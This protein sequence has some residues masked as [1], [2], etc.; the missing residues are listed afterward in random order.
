MSAAQWAVERVGED[1]VIT[2]ADD[3]DAFVYTMSLGMAA[4]IAVM[5]YDAIVSEKESDSGQHPA[6]D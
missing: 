6:D 4:T 3:D 1:V 5:L 2:I